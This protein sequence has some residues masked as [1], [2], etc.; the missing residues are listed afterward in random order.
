MNITLL[1]I[2]AIEAGTPLLFAILGEIINEKSGHLNLG[3]EGIMLIGAVIGFM[4][5]YYTNS[6][7]IAIIATIISGVLIS[8]IYAFITVTL[9]G[10]QVVTGLAITI[11]GVG[12]AGFFGKKMVGL[13]V[14]EKVKL[15]FSPVKIPI[16]SN[17]PYI[18]E[19]LFY[20]NVFVYF[21]M[22]LS[23]IIAIYFYKT[24]LG[25][26]LFAVGENPSAADA[27]GVRVTLTKYINI[28]TGGAICSLG[29]AYLSLVY[30][31]AWQQNVT[32][33]RG[34]IAV[35]LVIV[36]SWNPLFVMLSAYIFGGLDIVGYRLQKFNLPIS[37]YFIDMLPYLATIFVL[38]FS[39][40]KKSK[41]NLPP[42]WLGLPYF[43]EDR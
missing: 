26:S 5:A 35:A 34:F 39:S 40:I 21:G 23:I 29:G 24:S 43:R 17:I 9:R 37:Q 16:L 15:F 6:A 30:I 2:A 28:L 19:I 36:S 33:G 25:L 22:I 13:V 18:G 38:V 4:T 42:K 31:P 10:N 14:S 8:S 7:I 41:Q 11:F 20:H 1:L 27:S 32:A 12:F 3:V